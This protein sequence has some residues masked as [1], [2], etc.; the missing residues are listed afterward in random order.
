MPLCIQTLWIMKTLVQMVGVD[1]RS[2][3]LSLLIGKKLA[4]FFFFF[5]RIVSGL[6]LFTKEN[7][8]STNTSSLSFSVPVVHGAVPCW[9]VGTGSSLGWTR[10]RTE[11]NGLSHY[12][13]IVKRELHTICSLRVVF[14]CLFVFALPRMEPRATHMLDR[15]C[16]TELH[17]KASISSL[18]RSICDLVFA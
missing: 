4:F 8:W 11:H 9:A 13:L 10:N 14:I 5:L 15:C 1:R 12:L 18:I 16:H 6:F 17:P 7:V 3:L 2:N